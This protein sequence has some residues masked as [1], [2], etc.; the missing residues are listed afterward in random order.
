M[1]AVRRSSIHGRGC[2][3]TEPISE[4]ALIG[5]LEGE[6]ARVDGPHV[7]W[8]DDDDALLVTN[9]LRYLNHADDPNAVV[10]DLDVLAL[11]AIAV[12][13]EIT[14]HYGPDWTTA[15]T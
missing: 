4:H 12:G 13:E 8:F 15:S 1:F 3:A 2:F 14:I 5:R 9:D 11:R 6:P 10:E 7:I